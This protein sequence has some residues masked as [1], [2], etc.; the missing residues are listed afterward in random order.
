MICAGGYKVTV[1]RG[2]K[3]AAQGLEQ[4]IKCQTCANPNV[5]VSFRST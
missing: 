3:M 4:A 2:G 5:D 1:D